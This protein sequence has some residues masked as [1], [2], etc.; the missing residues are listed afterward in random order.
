MYT[1]QLKINTMQMEKDQILQYLICHSIALF[2][3]VNYRK[4]YNDFIIYRISV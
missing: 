3:T 1:I 4:I 2:Y